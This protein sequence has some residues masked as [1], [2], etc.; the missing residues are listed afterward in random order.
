MIAL[1]WEKSIG[2]VLRV[3]KLTDTSSIVRWWTLQHGV[4]DTVA[5]GARRST[6]SFA[7]KIDLFFTADISWATSKT[8]NLHTLRESSVQSYRPQLRLHYSNTLIASYFCAM[9]E[10][11]AEPESPEPEI[12]DLLTRALNHIEE[13][14][15]SLRALHHFERELARLHGVGRSGGHTAMLDLADLGAGLPALRSQLLQRLA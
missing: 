5:K 1:V 14:N 9:I 13:K 4:I 11:I 15:A 2:I 7:G 12:Y 3:T 8:G 6:S 10:K